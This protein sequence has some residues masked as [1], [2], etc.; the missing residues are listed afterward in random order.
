MYIKVVVITLS[1]VI[2]CAESARVSEADAEALNDE[3]IRLEILKQYCDSLD[4]A[5]DATEKEVCLHQLAKH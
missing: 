2:F 4:R 1:I 5:I 3:G